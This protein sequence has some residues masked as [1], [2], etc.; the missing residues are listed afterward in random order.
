MAQKPANA[1][2]VSPDHAA[3]A[4]IAVAAVV[5][6][7][8]Y[9]YARVD[10]VG[11]ISSR[12]W[13]SM[14]GTPRSVATHA[15]LA[16]LL[17]AVIPVAVARLILRCS[18]A[19]LGLGLGDWR[20]GVTLLAAGLPLAVLAGWIGSRSPLMQAVYPLATSA[21]GAGFVPYAL[22]LFLYFGAWEILFRGVLLFGLRHSTGE[23]TANASQTGLSMTA[24]FGRAINE[25]AIAFPA[26][27]LFGW[28]DLRVGSLWYLAI[29]HW[30][31][32]VSMEWFIGW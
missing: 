14:T 22:L 5:L 21:P 2:R 8:F 23:W 1:P 31:V 20:R 15:A 28:I 25:T 30:C 18:L 24:H 9:Y 13:S 16:V 4:L 10:T 17:L 3:A 6:T 19:D 29:V 32:G 26:G 12:G 27:L 11:V 7:V